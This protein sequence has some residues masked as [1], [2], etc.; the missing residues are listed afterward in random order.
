[1]SL[2]NEYVQLRDADPNDGD[3]VPWGQQAATDRVSDSYERMKA[4][5]KKSASEPAVE[6]ETP[7]LQMIPI[8]QI[9]GGEDVHTRQQLDH[10]TVA[11]YTEAW[12][13]GDTFPPIVLYHEDGAYWLADGAHR[14]ESRALAGFQDILAEVRP[15]GRRKA[16]LFALTCDRNVG[17][18]GRH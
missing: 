10:K 11:Q 15:G 1:M 18:H 13:A 7:T 16:I 9:M 17:S 14:V 4:S 2:P 8:S 12:K 6:V 5:R 3:A